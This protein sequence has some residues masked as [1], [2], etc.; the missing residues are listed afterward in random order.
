MILTCSEL[1]DK[2]KR[3]YSNILH[4]ELRNNNRC[5]QPRNLQQKN[6]VRNRGYGRQ[7]PLLPHLHLILIGMIPKILRIESN[8]RDKDRRECLL[9]LNL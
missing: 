2:I 5:R 1:L 7:H 9:R 6:K 8:R 4:R 3:T